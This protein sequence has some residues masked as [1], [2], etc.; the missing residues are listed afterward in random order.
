MPMCASLHMFT[1]H[2]FAFVPK[3]GY[4]F[5]HLTAH[6]HTLRIMGNASAFIFPCFI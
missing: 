5:A 4:A 3:Y 2:T 1:L 6:T